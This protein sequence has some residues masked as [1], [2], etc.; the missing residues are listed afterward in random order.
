MR[1]LDSCRHGPKLW[2]VESLPTAANDTFVSTNSYR[3]FALITS[4][5]WPPVFPFPVPKSLHL[6]LASK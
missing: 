6:L 1:L 3:V 2:Q 5:V 4:H